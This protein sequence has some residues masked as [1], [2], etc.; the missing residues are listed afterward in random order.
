[1]RQFVVVC[2]FKLFLYDFLADRPS[3]SPVSN[4]VSQVV[5]MRCGVNRF[6]VHRSFPCYQFFIYY[7]VAAFIWPYSCI[8][9]ILSEL[10]Y[11][12]RS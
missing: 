7:F 11:I 4:V 9:I 8:I 1:M 5:D 6:C 3:H 10:F 12:S 2:D